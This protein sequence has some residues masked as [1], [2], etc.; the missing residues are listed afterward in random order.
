[1]CMSSGS[2][3]PPPPQ[4]PTRFEYLP[5][6]QTSVQRQAADYAAAG[7]T[8]TATSSYGSELGTGGQQLSGA[9]K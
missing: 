8:N 7:Y 9:A 5:S 3:K 2:S 4:P 6:S 1:M